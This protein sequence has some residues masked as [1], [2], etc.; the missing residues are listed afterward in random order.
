MFSMSHGTAILAVLVLIAI[1]ALKFS[2]K[3]SPK[4]DSYKMK[5]LLSPAERSFYGVLKKASNGEHE[6]FTKVRLADLLM[7][8]QSGNNKAAL[9][10]IISKHI[11]FIICDSLTLQAKLAIE[12]DDK[13]HQRKDR[14]A[15]DK[16]LSEICNQ[17]GLPLINFRASK[18]YNIE[19][20]RKTIRDALSLAAGQG[21]QVEPQP[22]P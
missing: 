3:K 18:G 9:N 17:A 5:D 13:T 16:F 22:S 21:L 12:L 8:T 19:D 10:K 1:A 14:Q 20:V 6:I 4:E 7:P 11:D 15:R 2:A